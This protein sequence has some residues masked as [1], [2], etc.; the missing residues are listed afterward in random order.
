MALDTTESLVL[1]LEGFEGPL[2]LLLE[3]ARAQKVDLAKISILQLVEQFLSVIDGARRVR[4]ELAADWLVMAAW[5]TWLK[6][7][8]LVP[9]LGEPEDAEVAAEILQ[10]RLIELQTMREAAKWLGAQ[11]QLNWDVFERGL[12]ED[13]TELDRSKLKLDMT[14]LL[15]AYLAARRRA[16][17]KQRY[18]PKPMVY[19]SVQDALQRVGRL[20]GS[21]P[22][23]AS[24]EQF[25]PEGLQDGVPLRAAISST[26]I[27]GLEMAKHGQ[28]DLKQDEKFGPIFMRR[29]EER[30]GFDG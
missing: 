18:R 15:S 12:P 22:D 10:S 19:F 17:A 21:L 24:L 4:L 7:R 1:K 30:D 6:S 2:D 27:A 23:W 20:L 13:L 16:G 26:L 9:Q 8:L 14:G 28:L 11:P 3:L 5:L 29:K 25:L